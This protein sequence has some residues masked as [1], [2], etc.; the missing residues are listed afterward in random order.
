MAFVLLQLLLRQ[1]EHLFAHQS[2]HGYFEPFRARPFMTTPGATR[3]AFP[4]TEWACDALPRPQLGLA[5]AGD[6]SIRGIAQHA[7]NRGSF[8]AALACPSGNLAL[9]EQS[10]DGIDA[11]PL[12][13]INLKHHANDPGLGLDHF[14][15]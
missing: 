2:R 12:L 1:R 8:P 6:P 14:L 10:R 9:I 3:Q 4:L 7:P 11:E 15:E 13:G 5:I